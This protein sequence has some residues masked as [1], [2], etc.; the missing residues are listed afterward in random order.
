MNLQGTRNESPSLGKF[1]LVGAGPGDPGLITVK[2]K[3]LLEHA[4]VVVY[5]ALVTPPILAM[6]NPHAEKINGGKR[7]GNHSEKIQYTEI[8]DACIPVEVHPLKVQVF[9]HKIQSHHVEG[10]VREIGMN[11][12]VGDKSMILLLVF[13]SVRNKHHAFLDRCIFICP[14]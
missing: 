14:K 12:C 3:I 4:D 9:T 1:Y 5:D 7:R 8:N 10:Q 2:A 11:K 6:I 13:Y